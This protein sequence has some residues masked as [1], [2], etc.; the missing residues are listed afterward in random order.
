EASRARERAER[1]EEAQ[2]QYAARA[3][4]EQTSQDQQKESTAWSR[5]TDQWELFKRVALAAQPSPEGRIFR[6]EDIPWPMLSPPTSP[7]MITKGQVAAFLYSSSSGQGKSLK[8]RIRECLLTW[9]PDKFSG[10]WMRFVLEEDRARV[11]E[12]VSA[13]IRAGNE[14]MAEYASRRN[15]L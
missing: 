14:I 13:V 12:G 6:F 10:R 15:T 11:A 7:G 9:H 2:R 8:A 5:Y 4:S 3:E 1:A